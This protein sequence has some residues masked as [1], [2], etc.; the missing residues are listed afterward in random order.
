VTILTKECRADA[1][2]NR[3]KV[4]ERFQPSSMSKL[5]AYPNSRPPSPNNQSQSP[6]KL[7][8]MSSDITKVELS[9][10]DVALTLIML[11]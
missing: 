2:T 1:D 5:T 6:L 10:L 11:S 7:I 4:M 8:R 3:A 9:P